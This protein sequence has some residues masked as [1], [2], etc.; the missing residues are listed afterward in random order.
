MIKNQKNKLKKN[1]NN[2]ILENPYLEE[3]L[4]VHYSVSQ[5]LDLDRPLQPPFKALL[6]FQVKVRLSVANL[7]KPEVSFKVQPHFLDKHLH[8]E[9]SLFSLLKK[10]KNQIPS[11]TTMK[12]MVQGM[13]A[14]MRT[15]IN[16]KMSKMRGPQLNSRLR[17]SLL[18]RVHILKCSLQ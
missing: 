1:K 9:V 16:K 17:L 14:Q 6:F 10:F 11:L 8:L 13:M 4:R 2:L 18:K 3:L 5:Y 15:K 7:I 12:A